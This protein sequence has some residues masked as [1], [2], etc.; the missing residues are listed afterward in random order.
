MY[1]LEYPFDSDYV[2]KKKKSIK[3]ALLADGSTRLQKKIAVLGGSTINEIINI[4]ELFLL[5]AGIEPT[6]YQSEYAQYWQD[7]MF[8]PQELLD[9]QPDIVFIHTT[10]RN[11]AS[12]PTPRFSKEDTD[13]LLNSTFE[14]FKQMWQSVSEKFKCPIIQNNFELPFYRLMGNKD[15]SDYRGRSNFIT[16]LNTMLY[17]YSQKTDNF[18]INDINFISASYGLKEWSNP[19]FWNMYKYAMCIDAIPELAFNIANIIKSIFGKNK[20]ALALDLDNTLWGGVVGDDGVDNIEIG[21]ETGVSQSYYEFQQFIKS[22]K[23][24][25]IM[26]TVCSKN[27]HQNAVD[28][29]NHPEGVLKPDDFI[30]IKANWENKDINIANTAA[31]LN[32]LPESIVFVDD[33]PAEREIVKAQLNGVSAPVMDTVENYITTLD[34]NGFFEVTTFSEDDLKRNEM[35]KA[36]VERA[37]QQATFGNYEDYLLSMNMKATIDDFLPVYIQRITQLSN[38]SNQFNVTTKRYTVAEM[39]EV[40]ES[41]QYIRLYGKLIDKFGDNGVVSV[42]IGKK[43]GDVLNIDLWL[44]SCRVLKRDMELAMLDILV[45]KCIEQGVKTIKG[46]YYPTAKNN[47][48]RELYKTFGF[49]KINEDSE[50]NTIWEMAVDSY[51]NKNNVI[52]VVGNDLTENNKE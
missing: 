14:N 2:S 35:Y 22:Q 48:V 30:I 15:C 44:M 39:E 26:L 7:A 18:Y 25:G 16:R 20:K 42:V 31:E 8:P 4:M 29:L 37:A 9:F 33:N 41:D 34:R 40:F 32:I 49:E 36:N 12:Y 6:F 21:Q 23:D 10:N 1:Q 50:G 28:G 51:S 52:T 19:L 46:Y 3:K 13:S 47:M 24:L 5:N 43:D 27:D 17:C 45:Q 11:I 38:K